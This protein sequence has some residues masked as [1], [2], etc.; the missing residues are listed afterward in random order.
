MSYIPIVTDYRY[1]QPGDPCWPT[2]EEIQKLKL[3]IDDPDHSLIDDCMDN[4]PL[5]TS[6]DEPG[7]KIQNTWYVYY[8]NP[9]TTDM[10]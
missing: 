3:D 5:F 8:I 2:K 9:W 6:K 10:F 4:F 1:C 7:E